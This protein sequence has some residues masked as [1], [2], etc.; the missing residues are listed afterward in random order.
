MEKYFFAFFYDDEMSKYAEAVK[1]Q[2]PCIKLRIQLVKSR[3]VITD[4]AH[5]DD[6]NQTNLYI[7]KKRIFDFNPIYCSNIL[8]T[9]MSR[10]K[11]AFD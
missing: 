1:E 9:H 3:H 2:F 7:C 10:M 6:D 8:H 4:I 11:M 5:D